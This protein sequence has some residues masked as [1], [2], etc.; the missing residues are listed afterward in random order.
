MLMSELST[1]TASRS[2][3]RCDPTVRLPT[4]GYPRRNTV[5]VSKPSSTP[6]TLGTD[7]FTAAVGPED[8]GINLADWA[9]R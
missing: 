9:L 2:A 4:P 5:Q 1:S 3:A 7:P 8:K 6:L